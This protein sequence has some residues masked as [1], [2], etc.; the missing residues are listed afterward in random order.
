MFWN[1]KYDLDFNWGFGF[2]LWGLAFYY[3]VWR[4]IELKLESS[5]R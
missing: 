4:S 2:V 1:S 3:G 5:D